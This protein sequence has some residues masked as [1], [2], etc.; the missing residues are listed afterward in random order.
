MK[1]LFCVNRDIYANI[2][3]NRIFPALSQ[4]RELPEN[5]LKVLFSESVAGTRA[6]G[7]ALTYLRF[8]EQDLLNEF[9]FPQQEALS[10]IGTGRLKTFNQLSHC[11][12]APMRLISSINTPEVIA[13][14][15]Q[16]APDVIV[17]I[18]FGHIFKGPVLQ[19]P[20][21]GILNLHSGLLPQYRGIL[22]TFWSLLH[23]RSEYG[24]TLHTVTDGTI[25]TG[26]IVD[27]QVFP[28]QAGQSLF[29]HTVALYEPAAASILKALEQYRQGQTPLAR[30]QAEAESAYYTLPTPDDFE[31]LIALGH[32]ILNRAAYYQWLAQY[33]PKPNPVLA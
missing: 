16:F 31:Q 23:Q 12:Q 32:P 7:A 13:E 24:F 14:M 15:A 33:Q 28:V 26:A 27:R 29:E 17:S 21:L 6:H 11:Y 1:L 18:R 9:L 30:P 25:D 5:E 3:L 19:I 2:A 22:A 10:A 20:R 8:Y 4:T